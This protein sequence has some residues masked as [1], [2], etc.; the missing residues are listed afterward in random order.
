MT[1]FEK[2]ASDKKSHTGQ[3]MVPI[4]IQSFIFHTLTYSLVVV[5]LKVMKLNHSTSFYSYT[6]KLR[7][8]G[9]HCC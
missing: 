8:V 3:L 7:F 9:M 1:K 5:L 2:G 4:R 6:S